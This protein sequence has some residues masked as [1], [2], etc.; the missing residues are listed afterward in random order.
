MDFAQLQ[1]QLQANNDL[2]NSVIKKLNGLHPEYMDMKDVIQYTTL[3]ES[4][5]KRYQAEI[6]YFVRDR[7]KIFKRVDVDKFINQNTIRK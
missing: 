4:T 1:S 7:K 3:S 6:G 2:L 5:I